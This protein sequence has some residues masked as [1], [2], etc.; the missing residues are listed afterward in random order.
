LFRPTDIAE[1]KGIA[2]KAERML[3]WKAQCGM[4]EV[5]ANMIGAELALQSG[6]A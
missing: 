1:G 4:K 2:H 6:N 5:I 3:G